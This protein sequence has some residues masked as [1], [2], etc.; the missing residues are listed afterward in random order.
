[1]TVGSDRGDNIASQHLSLNDFSSFAFVPAPVSGELVLLHVRSSATDA[2]FQIVCRQ[3]DTLQRLGCHDVSNYH[4]IFEPGGL[5]RL[6]VHLFRVWVIQLQHSF[7]VV[8]SP[9]MIAGP[10]DG[11]GFPGKSAALDN[12]ACPIPGGWLRVCQLSES[13]H[14]NLPYPIPSV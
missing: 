14:T 12:V 7:G 2:P 10:K 8:I 3:L 1:M 5:T 13:R 9:V 6:V 11:H 4:R